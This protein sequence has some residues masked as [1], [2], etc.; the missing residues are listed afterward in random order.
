MEIK[1]RLQEVFRDVFDDDSL[2][3]FD[4]TT[5]DDVEEWD[6]L[7]Q[8]QIIISTEQEFRITFKTPEVMELTNVGQFIA[9]I[10]KKLL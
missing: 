2:E 9:L 3:I 6:S 8:V 4:E 5:A 10:Q 7:K 1:T